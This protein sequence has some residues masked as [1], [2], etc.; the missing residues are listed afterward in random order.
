MSD[1]QTANATLAPTASSV[2]TH[3]VK[4]IVDTPDAVKIESIE[5]EGKIIL[6]VRVA[7]GDLGRVIGRR[8]R[9]AQSIRAVVRAAASRD[10]AEV[11]V[12]F[13]DD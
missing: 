9:T 13:L 7:D 5:D 12:D 3:I 11:D 4:S 2:L 8:G 6:E 10:N 1:A